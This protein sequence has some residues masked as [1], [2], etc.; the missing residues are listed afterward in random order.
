MTAETSPAY[1]PANDPS[2][3]GSEQDAMDPRN[4]ATIGAFLAGFQ[5]KGPAER[6]NLFADDLVVD[7]WMLPGERLVGR[8]DV[9]RYF[10]D[11]IVESFEDYKFEVHETLV[12]GNALVV[13]GHFTGRFVRDYVQKGKRSIPAHGRP[14]R[15]TARDIYYFREGRIVRIQYANDTLTVARQLGVLPDNGDPW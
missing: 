3:Q 7:D 8:Q 4:V 13:L 11:P 15:W 12:A 14:V 10:F 6:I 5:A 1:G 9:E 2:T